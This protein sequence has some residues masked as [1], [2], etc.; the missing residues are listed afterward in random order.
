M[1]D[2]ALSMYSSG[3]SI[4]DIAK[5]F[6]VAK[7]TIS[8]QFAKAGVVR[9]SPSESVRLSLLD[10]GKYQR[11]G[12]PRAYSLNETFF[13]ELTPESAYVIGLIQADG[14]LSSDRFSISAKADDSDFLTTLALAMGS[15]RPIQRVAHERGDVSRLAINSARMAEALRAWGIHT[16]RT[17]TASTHDALLFNRDYW[18]GVVDGDGS[19]C[20]AKRNQSEI[21]TLVGSRAICAQF[22]SFCRRWGFGSGVAVHPCRR[23]FCVRL[24]SSEAVGVASL[25]YRDAALALPRKAAMY[26]SFITGDKA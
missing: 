2:S 21:L 10:E 16:P 6:G 4:C 13:E 24:N 26:H 7:S 12:R 8:R 20:R 11:C 9:R 23:I 1:P 18:R 14:T 25:L 15:N 5:R 22:L 3:M 19:L 17:F